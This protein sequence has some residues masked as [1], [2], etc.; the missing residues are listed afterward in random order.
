VNKV[1]LMGNIANDVEMKQ[2]QAGKFI[3]NIRV[4]CRR[5]QNETDFI[6]CVA[7][8]KTAE[9]IGKHFRKGSR[10]LVEGNIKTGSYDDRQT[11]KKVFT[12]DVWI[13]NIDFPEK[14]QNGQNGQNSPP[15]QGYNQPHQAP[16]NAPA[17]NQPQQGY[18]Q[19]DDGGRI[20]PA[21]D[22]YDYPLPY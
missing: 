19:R 20:P 9:L 10:I 11:G 13:S 18:N 1:I 21:P 6:N 17:Y 22:Y 16:P 7:F 12:T 8:D 15:Q 2:T 5:S 3:T 4:A 14:A